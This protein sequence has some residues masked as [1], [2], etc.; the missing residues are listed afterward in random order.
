MK[1]FPGVAAL[2]ALGRDAVERAWRARTDGA[3]AGLDLG[4]E[5]DLA[6]HADR[7]LDEGGIDVCVLTQ[8][9]EAGN[10]NP[11]LRSVTLGGCPALVLLEDDFASIVQTVRLGRRIYDNIRSAMRYIVSVKVPTAG[12]SLLPIALGGPVFLLPVHIVF[13]EFVV[14]PACAI[15]FEAEAGDEDAMARA[16]RDRAVQ[17]HSRRSAAV[18]GAATRTPVAPWPACSSPIHQPRSPAADRIPSSAD[19][20]RT[21]DQGVAAAA[22]FG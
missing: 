22:C 11:L 1:A 4:V 3:S 20:R 16:P 14:N 6:R 12:M 5:Q 15:V 17:P 18:T 8:E 10:A 2:E 9:R 13:L 7:V 21:A 19:A